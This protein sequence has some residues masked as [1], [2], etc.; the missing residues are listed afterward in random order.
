M[1]WNEQT[2]ERINITIYS[3][4]LGALNICRYQTIAKYLL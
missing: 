3:K 4:D 1:N 2:N